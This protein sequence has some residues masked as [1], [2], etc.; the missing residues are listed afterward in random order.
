MEECKDFSGHMYNICTGNTD[1]AKWKINEYRK[2]WGMKPLYQDVDLPPKNVNITPQPII[3]RSN[4]HDFQH[5]V[6]G[7]YHNIQPG[8]GTQLLKIYKKNGVPACT[9]CFELAIKM[10]DWG[11]D[12]CEEDIDVI[13]RDMLPRALLWIAENKPWVHSL[14]PDTVEETGVK[15][16]LKSD[17]KKAINL[18]RDELKNYI[19]K[20]VRPKQLSDQRKSGCGCRKKR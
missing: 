4:I 6:A 19:P 11:P 5:M 18:A 14:L 9:A 16:K 3:N 10:N 8:P 15:M 1:M 2:K 20:K 17:V 7:D 12:K 13:I